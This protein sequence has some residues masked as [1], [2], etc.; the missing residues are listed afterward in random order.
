MYHRGWYKLLADGT[1]IAG[2]FATQY[3][4]DAWRGA[5]R[6]SELGASIFFPGL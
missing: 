2:P 5:Y 6:L 1:P 3:G 4:A